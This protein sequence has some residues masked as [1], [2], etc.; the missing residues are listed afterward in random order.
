MKP[1]KFLSLS[2]LLAF[3]ATTAMKCQKDGPNCHHDIIIRNASSST[4]IFAL[5]GYKDSLCHLAKRK[6]L[7]A[8]EQAVLNL[9]YCWEEELTNGRTQEIYI[10]DTSQFNDPNIFYSCDSIEIK[11][12]VLR[13]YELTLDD[14][15]KNNF[16]V[17]YP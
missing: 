14:L 17:T 5:E 6:E 12:K 1:Q 15:K 8:G 16:T 11:N 4:V 10:V 13:H 3:F 7:H 2:L 9:R